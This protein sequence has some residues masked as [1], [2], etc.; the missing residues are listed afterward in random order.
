MEAGVDEVLMRDR[1]RLLVSLGIPPYEPTPLER[2]HTMIFQL[3]LQ[4]IGRTT[5]AQQ[6]MI[7]ERIRAGLF[8]VDAPIASTRPIERRA[9]RPECSRCG[10][11][12]NIFHSGR[13]WPWRCKHLGKHARSVGPWTGVYAAGPM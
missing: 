9:P 1:Q 13:N 4:R 10:R 3:T 8:P 11:E 2:L 12:S 5:L 7:G 6:Q